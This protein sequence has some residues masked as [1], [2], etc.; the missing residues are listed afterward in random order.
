MRCERIQPDRE[1]Q[2]RPEAGF[3]QPLTQGERV[4]QAARRDRTSERAA[5]KSCASR[6]RSSAFALPTAAGPGSRA[7]STE[8][9]GSRASRRCT[10]AVLA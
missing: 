10:R 9:S 4:R 7:C 5:R 6:A 2:G 1:H 8:R 3:V